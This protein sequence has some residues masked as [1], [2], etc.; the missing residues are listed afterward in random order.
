MNFLCVLCVYYTTRRS[1]RKRADANK[2]GKIAREASQ[3]TVEG[4][5][6]TFGDYIKSILLYKS[7]VK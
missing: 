6:S 3:T 1:F 5:S 2:Y 7:I 4:V